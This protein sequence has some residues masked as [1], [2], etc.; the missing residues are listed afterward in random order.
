MDW[1]KV[2]P[3]MTELL[4]RIL[5]PF[6]AE[7]KKMF[8]CPVYFV[9]NNMFAGVHAD[10]IFIRLNAADRAEIARLSDEITVFEPA[11]GRPMKEYMVVPESRLTD[12]DFTREWL[13][14]SWNYVSS[15]PVKE[16]K[17]KKGAAM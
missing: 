13:G 11:E 9:N 6:R 15:L 7:R 4:D 5:A 16:P 17:P 3:E 8:G 10:N 1:K 2:S 12:A 14:R